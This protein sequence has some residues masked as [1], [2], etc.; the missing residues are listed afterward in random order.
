MACRGS[1]YLHQCSADLLLIGPFEQTS[2]KL[3][4][5]YKIVIHESAFQNAVC[6]MI[7]VLSRGDELMF[8]DIGAGTILGL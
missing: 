3:E 6:E 1:H 8:C 2:V 5:K 4:S 7:A